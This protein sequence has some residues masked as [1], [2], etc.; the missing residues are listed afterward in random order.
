MS[1]ISSDGKRVHLWDLLTDVPAGK[2]SLE[3]RCE[4]RRE[5][6]MRAKNKLNVAARV[7][8]QEMALHATEDGW[9]LEVFSCFEEDGSR[10]ILTLSIPTD[11]SMPIRVEAPGERVEVWTGGGKG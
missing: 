1:S 8:G 11:K 5:L 6:G 7:H 4:R 3:E 10:P 9:D 2:T